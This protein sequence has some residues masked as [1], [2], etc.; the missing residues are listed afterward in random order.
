[1]TPTDAESTVPLKHHLKALELP[2]VAGGCEKGATRAAAETVAHLGLLPQVGEPELIE[3]G[4]KAA[5]R[6]LKAARFPAEKA[7]AEFDSAARP[8]VNTP[9]VPDLAR[10]DDLGRRGNVLR[11]GPTGTGETHPATGWAMAACA[12]GKRV[13]SWR[14][15]D[16]ITTLRE[17]DDGRHLL[18]LRR[19][20]AELDLPVVDEFGDVPASKAGAGVLFDVIGTAY[21]RPRVILTTNPPPENWAEVLGG[22]RLTG[23]ALDR[24]THRRP[25]IEATGES[26]R[27]RDAKRRRRSIP[28]PGA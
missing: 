6:R 23:A 8:S 18:P 5:A 19:R 13:R 16:L 21:E 20:W 12:Q 11:V 22:E 2:A 27:R 28:A 17:A 24:I 14:V 7:R 9:L 15:T 4:R 25:I 10:G 1:M 26:D 3:R